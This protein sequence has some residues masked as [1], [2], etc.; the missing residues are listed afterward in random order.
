MSWRET[1]RPR[2]H[3][4]FLK[5]MKKYLGKKEYKTEK[6]KEFIERKARTT[7]QKARPTEIIYEESHQRSILFLFLFVLFCF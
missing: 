6:K 1:M 7:W 2:N 4:A 3:S 5:K